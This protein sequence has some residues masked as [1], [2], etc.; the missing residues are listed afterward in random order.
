MKTMPGRKKIHVQFM[1]VISVFLLIA[2]WSRIV[3]S[4]APEHITIA[5]S[6][7]LAPFHFSDEDGQPAGIIIDLW[8][9]WSEKTGIAVDF[10]VADWNETLT[11]VGS[12]SADVHAGL[13]Y[14]QERD[15]FL[16]YGSAFTKMETH[17]FHHVSLP[18]IKGIKALAAYRVGVIAGDYVENYLLERLPQGTVVP[19]ANYNVMMN[20]LKQGTL[21]VFA[22]DTLPGLFYL[23]KNGLL[24]EFTFVSG[25][26]LY[27]NEL[28]FAVQEGNQTLIDIINRGLG[29]I[30]EDEKREI[31]RRWIATGEKKGKA[32]IISIDR[33]Y[34]PFTFVNALGRPSGLF[35]DLWR[36]WAQ[37]TGR[38]IRFRPSGWIETIEGLRAGEVDIHSGL[39]F[40]EE[41]SEWIGFSNKIYGTYS[42]VYHKVGVNQ[43]S[44]IDM[45]ETNTIGTQFG[46]YQEEAFR[47]AYP[48]VNTLSFGS[49]QDLIEAL[50]N[51]KIKAFVQEEQFMESTLDRLGLHGE[52]ITRPERLF[53][54]TIHAGVLKGNASLLEEIN[55][56]FKE[57]DPKELSVIESRWIHNPEDQF[58]KTA[59]ESI[60][61]SPDE[62]SWRADHPVLRIAPDPGFAPLEF[63]D[64]QGRYQ[65]L[66]ADFLNLAAKRLGVRLEAIQKKDF[67]A[68]IEALRSGEV[69]LIVNSPTEE[70]RKDFL[71]TDTF[72][73]F[74]GA[75]I[76]HDGIQGQIRLEDLAGKEVLVATGWPDVHYLKDRYPDI[77]VVEVESILDGLT[78]A[79]FKQYDYAFA[80]FP[81]AS[82]LI[83]EHGLT[84]LRVA[85]TGGEV[86]PGGVMVR[87]DSEMLRTVFNKALVSITEAERRS[88]KRQWIPGLS[89]FET[90]LSKR[91][92]LNKAERLWLTEHPVVRIGMDPDWAPVEFVDKEGRF[93]GI[94]MDYLEQLGGLLGIR[95]EAVEGL[96]WQQIVIAMENGELDL[97]A[98]VVRTPEREARYRFT[99]PYLTMPINIFARNDVTYIGNLEALSDKHVA[100]IEGYAIH[101]WLKRDHPQI[102]LLPA[103]SVPDAL[104]MVANGRAYAFVGNMVTTSYYI[105][106]LQLNQ[107]RVAGETPYINAQS[108]AV[109][110]DW[111]ALAGILQKGLDTIPDTEKQA[112]FN[113]W[114]SVKYEHGFD[115]SLLWKIGIPAFS[116]VIFLLYWNHRLGGEIKERKRA[117]KR[118]IE[119]EEKIRAMS[120][121][122]HDAVI[123]ID[124]GGEVM[125]WNTAAEEMFG[126]AAREALGANMHTLFVPHEFRDKAVEGVRHFART[127]EGPVIGRVIESTALRRD[128]TSFPVEIAISSFNLDGVWFAVGSVRDI[129]ERKKA[130]EQLEFTQHS[131]DYAADTVFWVDP[132]NGKLVYVNHTAC[133]FLGYSSDELLKMGILKV[134]IDFPAERFPWL[135][136]QLQ[137]K[138]SVRFES[139]YRGKN[140]T[141]FDVEIIASLVKYE[142]RRLLVATTRDITDRKKDEEQIR[143]LSNA[144]EQSPVWVVVTDTEGT[145]EYVNPRFT[146][147]TGYPSDEA[148]GKNPK[149]L[150]SGQTPPETYQEM[151]DRILAGNPWDGQLLDR[152][153]N[154]E[155]FW[156]HLFISSVLNADGDVTHFIGLG[157]D[158]TEQK[159]L[160]EER[161]D[162]YDV[163][164]SSI[165][166]ASN[167]QHSILPESEKLEAAFSEHFI[168]WEPRD[169]V[170][171][172]IYFFKPWGLGKMFALGDCTGHGVPGAFMTM[173]ANGALD[174]ATM[175]TQPGDSATLL[176]RVHQLIQNALGQQNK[177]S[178]SD[179]GLDLGLCY[180]APRNR[181]MIFSG[182]RFS[183]FAVEDGE[184]IEIKG[185]KKYGLGYR[186]T[187]HNVEFQNLD[188]KIDSRRMF[189]M[190]S[191]G[192]IDQVGGPKRRSFGKKRFKRLLLEMESMP[193]DRRADHIRQALRAYQGDEKRRDDVSVVGFSFN[194]WSY[195]AA[196][197]GESSQ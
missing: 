9:L 61:L 8:R 183:L 170:G 29:L 34:E 55:N 77:K 154:G 73:G 54:S 32:V 39:S 12:G 124:S 193:M 72:F 86:F 30:T 66:W 152:R 138:E 98:S 182:A 89:S 106:K 151:W 159:A 110:K 81:T 62:A 93:Q 181:K 177:G 94:S 47:K 15:K 59:A 122:S 10:K 11:M 71:F 126:Y 162:A 142:N 139:R 161:D 185:N 13:F 43:P 130:E 114:V 105:S 99:T 112:I 119:S 165:R 168:L 125:F 127:G 90:I 186:A 117:E 82:Y 104:E 120:D 149:V 123:M 16:D 144:V 51:D 44:A 174:M 28:F 140:G 143:K 24:S 26:P 167:I 190:T 113:R 84:G 57:L 4:A 53:P 56:G 148:I 115:Y 173:I 184:V 136:E 20:A 23:K 27:Q 19:Y 35:V 188:I 158:I 68:A 146:E 5:C 22:A 80:F 150:A 52:F 76:T 189:Y 133:N 79:S 178:K 64:D 45:Y 155:L 91:V 18:Q 175:E 131:V 7:D 37:K 88:I 92:E 137:E 38:K 14:N 196:S 195:P 134:D 180:I 69:D 121:A 95:F 70:F 48:N 101:E 176:Q 100:V 36:E 187:P 153:K 40:S 191:D 67:P 111:P 135:L 42:R 50:L 49:N 116:V 3:C 107:V 179:D 194:N 157:E 169:R 118:L 164:S 108:M 103:K 17:Y 97:L 2:G 41:R 132:E 156:A 102:I 65:G 197:G 129:T 1:A 63:F 25:K 31:N 60:D 78:K 58:Y 83:Q 172:D 109:R 96:T 21:K 160:Q 166:Y 46:T 145:I 147:I 6:K 85:G 87:K 128:G 171:G 192:L 163:I 75:I 74:P 33:D 141:I